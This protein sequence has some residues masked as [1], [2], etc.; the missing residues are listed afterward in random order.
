LK[1]YNE[2]IRSL[3]RCYLQAYYQQADAGFQLKVMVAELMM[4]YQSGDYGICQQRCEQVRKI[5]KKTAPV[6]AH[7]AEWKMIQLI[8]NLCLLS[9]KKPNKYIYNQACSLR[10]ELQQPVLNRGETILD[11]A[12]WC[13]KIRI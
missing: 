5:A 8:D 4:H 2:A 11:Y 10:D 3:V 12:V 7:P 13:S 1:K 9:I 6:S